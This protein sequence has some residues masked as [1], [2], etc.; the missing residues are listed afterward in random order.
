MKF[1]LFDKGVMQ[2]IECVLFTLWFGFVMTL[3]WC[4]LRTLEI[5]LPWWTEVTGATKGF[6]LILAVYVVSLYGRNK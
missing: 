2:P 6:M 3:L 4:T 1:E 5:Y